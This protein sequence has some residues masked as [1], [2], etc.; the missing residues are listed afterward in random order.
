MNNRDI[1]GLAARNLLRRK[2]RSLL[3]VAGVV[4]GTSAIL[5]LLSIG[6][7]L[8]VGY[9]EQIAGYGDLH[10]IRVYGGGGYRISETSG[11]PEK[12]GVLD[13][14]A[15]AAFEKIKG[16][17][18]AS[19]KISEYLTLGIG[20]YIAQAEVVGIRPEVMEKFNYEVEEG[21][22]LQPGDK[23]AIVFGKEVPSWFYNPSQND[24]GSWGGEPKVNVITDKIIISADYSYGQKRRQKDKSE[25]E[26]KIIYKEYKMKGVGFLTYTGDEPDYCVYMN[27]D[28]LR[29]IKEDTARARKDSYSRS[30]NKNEY[31]QALVYVGNIDDV[32]QVSESIREKGFNTHSLNDWLKSMQETG[33]KIQMM[34]AFIGGISLIVAALGITNTMVMSIYERTREIGVMKVI[35][36]NLMDIGKLFLLEAM[37]IGLVGGLLGLGFSKLISLLMNTVLLN[38]MSGMLGEIGAGGSVVS[39]IPLWLAVAAPLFSTLIGVFSGFY[40]AWRA[41]QISALESLRNE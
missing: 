26:K 40:P 2:T 5:L 32:Q 9:Q 37:M 29:T 16:V 41:M 38:F 4:V 36:A 24:W 18:A 10:M 33:K 1:L 6:F 25:E 12:E 22:L 3:A 21:R 17:D 14:K 7:G 11:K 8:S 20:K 19:P 34:L 27:I 30:E 23:N 15:I 35:G 31:Q 39:V 13:D 28:T